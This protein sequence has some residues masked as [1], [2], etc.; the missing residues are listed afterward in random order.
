MLCL[1]E[2]YRLAKDFGVLAEQEFPA[3]ECAQYTVNKN[4]LRE[5]PQTRKQMALAAQLVYHYVRHL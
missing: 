4:V 1:G 3:R 5:D 2:S